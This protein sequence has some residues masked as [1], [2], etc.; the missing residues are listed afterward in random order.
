MDMFKNKGH[1]RFVLYNYDNG[2]FSFNDHNL[3]IQCVL[4]SQ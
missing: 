4:R 2:L 1:L 3:N